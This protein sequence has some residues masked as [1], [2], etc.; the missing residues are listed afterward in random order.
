MPIAGPRRRL[1]PAAG[2]V[3]IN[4]A[5]RCGAPAGKYSTTK[6]NL[7][8]NND[9]L[10]LEGKRTLKDAAYEWTLDRRFNWRF[11]ITVKN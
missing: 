3:P 2:A 7:L 9:I 11:G 8:E 5:R 6:F 10:H 4:E 1:P